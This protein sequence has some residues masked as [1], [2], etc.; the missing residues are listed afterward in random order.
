MAGPYEYLHWQ[1]LDV[2]RELERRGRE[3]DED[4]TCLQT[5]VNIYGRRRLGVRFAQPRELGVRRPRDDA[6][7]ASL[8]TYRPLSGHA[9]GNRGHPAMPLVAPICRTFV[10]I[11]APRF[12]L[13]TSSPPGYSAE[14]RAKVRHGG[15]WLESRDFVRP[16]WSRS[17]WF[18]KRVSEQFGPG[19]DPRG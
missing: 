5:W 2:K 4:A 16:N 14:W 1:R 10:S 11:G 15:K 12:E 7:G 19:L 3:P 8:M 18:R 13:G 6:S 17:A 9:E